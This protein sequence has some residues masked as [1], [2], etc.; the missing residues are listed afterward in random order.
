MRNLN[1]ADDTVTF[2]YLPGFG[3][4]STKGGKFDFKKKKNY[5]DYYYNEEQYQE[6]E[7]E[8]Q[9]EKEITI[10]CSDVFAMRIMST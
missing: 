6:E 2:E 5:N 3:K 4:A 9:E 10:S 8:E 1:K 7:E